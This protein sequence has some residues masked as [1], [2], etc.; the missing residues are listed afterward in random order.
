[1]S[2]VHEA[3]RK[4]GQAVW[5]TPAADPN[6]TGIPLSTEPVEPVP[7]APSGSAT[8][9]AEFLAA[10]PV[11]PLQPPKQA[12]LVDPS[13]PHEAPMEEFRSLRTRLNHMQDQRPIHTAVV[14]SASPT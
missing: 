7:S 1:M 10:V 5:D 14:T 3:L 11:V 13:R 9:L 6:G 4:A 12:L 2:R 8:T